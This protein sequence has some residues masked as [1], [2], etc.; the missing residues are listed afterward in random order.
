MFCSTTNQLNW[1]HFFKADS[2]P[3]KSSSPYVSQLQLPVSGPLGNY[4]IDA[5]KKMCIVHLEFALFGM[6]ALVT[7]S[8][9]QW[10]TTMIYH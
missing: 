8:G 3:L 9:V 2:G 10:F 1:I 7:V 6:A 5:K 4:P